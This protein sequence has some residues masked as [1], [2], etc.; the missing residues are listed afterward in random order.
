MQQVYSS[1]NCL[2]NTRPKFNIDESKITALF[3]ASK[4]GHMDVAKML[5]ENGADLNARGIFFCSFA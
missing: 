4:N 5:V 3:L 1:T 2:A